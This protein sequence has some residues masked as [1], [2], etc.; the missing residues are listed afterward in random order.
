MRFCGGQAPLPASL[1]HAGLPTAFT[2]GLL[3]PLLCTPLPPGHFQLAA[4]ETNSSRVTPLF[5]MPPQPQNVPQLW[6]LGTFVTLKVQ[7]LCSE[8]EIQCVVLIGNA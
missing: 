7:H 6:K 8:L 3:A 5:C 1:K 2:L 4:K